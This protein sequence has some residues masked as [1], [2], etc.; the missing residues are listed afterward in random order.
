MRCFGP[1]IGRTWPVEQDGVMRVMRIGKAVV[2]V[3][4]EQEARWPSLAAE[5]VDA[6]ARGRS[7]VPTVWFRTDARVSGVIPVSDRVPV[8]F[9]DED[10][11]IDFL[12]TI[13]LL[14]SEAEPS[15][16]E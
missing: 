9:A 16:P 1:G 7:P 11:P 14:G 10:N 3:S 6:V 4:Q 5:A 2:G 15:T 13:T 8:S 12:G